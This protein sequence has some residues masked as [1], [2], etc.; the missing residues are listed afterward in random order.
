MKHQI[1]L[2]LF[3]V[4]FIGGCS[5][6]YGPKAGIGAVMG[7]VAGGVAGSEFGDGSGQLAAVGAGTLLGA[8]IGSEIGSSLDELDRRYAEEAYE[9]ALN[10]SRTGETTAWQNPN[11]GN[12]GAYTPTLAY[13]TE[14]G[15]YCREFVQTVTVENKTQDASGT[16]CRLEDGTWEIIKN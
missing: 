10:R 9:N 1:V 4:L 12:S 7:A 15:Q 5:D 8:F 13:Q 2:L 14:A 11:T 3:F 16:A 6:G